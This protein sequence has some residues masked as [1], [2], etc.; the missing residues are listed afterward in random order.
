MFFVIVVFQSVDHFIGYLNTNIQTLHSQLMPDI[1]PHMIEEIWTVILKSFHKQ[2]EEG[3]GVI[4]D[5]YGSQSHAHHCR[6]W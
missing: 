1:Y 3:V 5:I 4:C 2:L 6:E